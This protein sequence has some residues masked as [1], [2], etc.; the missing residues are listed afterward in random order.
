MVP[1]GGGLIFAGKP[2]L[3]KEINESYPG[4]A[5]MNCVLDVFITLMA[6]GETG[7]RNK[8]KTRKECY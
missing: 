3:I 4:R 7:L 5:S 6:L 1:V 2:E 8:I